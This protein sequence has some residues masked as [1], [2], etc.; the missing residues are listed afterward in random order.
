MSATLTRPAPSKARRPSRTIISRLRLFLQAGER[1]AVDCLHGPS[2]DD[3]GDATV[4]LRSYIEDSHLPE[5]ASVEDIMELTFRLGAWAEGCAVIADGCKK[6]Q[7]LSA[8][9]TRLP[10]PVKDDPRPGAPRHTKKTLNAP[11]ARRTSCKKSG[12]RF[13]HKFAR[14]A[15]SRALRDVTLVAPMS[16]R[17]RGPLFLQLVPDARGGR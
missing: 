6:S 8:A 5:N 15:I 11:R 16:V 10:T 1:H 14:L 4:Y 9:G 17:D 12:P 3:G 2:A 13:T 7:P